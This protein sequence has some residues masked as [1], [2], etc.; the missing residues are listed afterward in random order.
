MLICKNALNI[1]KKIVATI[2]CIKD[3]KR[4]YNLLPSSSDEGKELAAMHYLLNDIISEYANS[5]LIL[6]FEGSDIKGVK[7]FYLQF[8]SKNQPYFR[9]HQNNLPIPL[10]WVKR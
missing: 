10:K 8:G 5:K 3:Q 7:Q 6:D 9:I 4:I 1:N 2:V